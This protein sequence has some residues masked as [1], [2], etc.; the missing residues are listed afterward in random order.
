M[1][2]KFSRFLYVSACSL[3]SREQSVEICNV[4]LKTHIT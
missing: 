4:N 3:G 2:L 1:S